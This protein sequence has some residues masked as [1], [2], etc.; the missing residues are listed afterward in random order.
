MREYQS[1][2]CKILPLSFL[3]FFSELWTRVQEKK[4]EKRKWKRTKVLPTLLECIECNGISIA[5]SRDIVQV[6]NMYSRL[7]C[8]YIL[9]SAG[10]SATVHY[11]VYN[12]FTT[13]NT[14]IS[15]G[16]LRNSSIAL[17]FLVAVTPL[18]CIASGHTYTVCIVIT[19]VTIH[20]ERSLG[21]RHNF[22][23]CNLLKHSPWIVRNTRQ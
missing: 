18:P 12:Y 9:L 10:A 5:T 6:T 21:S 1:G 7:R 4:S 15:S 17:W 23:K 14:Q 2:L 11:H 8:K 16:L 19:A 22:S 20:R 3:C 13:G